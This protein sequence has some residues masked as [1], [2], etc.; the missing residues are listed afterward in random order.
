M[1]TDEELKRINELA[2]KA[3][4]ETLTKEEKQEQHKLRQKYLQNIRSSF[5]NQLKSV[6][7]VDPTGEDVTPKKIK[8]LKNKDR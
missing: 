5:K 3:K 6:K 7:I 1:I 4:K 8:D 2:K